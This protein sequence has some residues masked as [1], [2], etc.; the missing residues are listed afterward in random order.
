MCREYRDEI[1][2]RYSE[3]WPDTA[4]EDLVLKAGILVNRGAQFLW[5]RVPKAASESLTEIFLKEW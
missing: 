3:V 1:S 4:Y 2:E 5:C